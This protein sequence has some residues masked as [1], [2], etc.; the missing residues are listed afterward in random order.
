MSAVVEITPISRQIPE[1][2][3]SS[4]FESDTDPRIQLERHSIDAAT[5]HFVAKW[6][7]RTDYLADPAVLVEAL[8]E[9]ETWA[10]EHSGDSVAEYYFTLRTS[11]DQS[12]SSLKAEFDRAQ[13]FGIGK[14]NEMRFFT[15]GI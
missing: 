4:L 8:D 2:D 7:P 14:K 10:R 5:Q 12:N 11:Q 15:Q 6:Q 9:Y 3:L 1:W 13:E